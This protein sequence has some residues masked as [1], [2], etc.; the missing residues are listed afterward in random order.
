MFKPSHVVPAA[1]LIVLAGCTSAGIATTTMPTPASTTSPPPSTT[2][3]PSTW[4]QIWAGP[5]Y[6]ALFDLALAG[7]SGILAVGATNHLHLPPYSGDALFVKLTLDG[8]TSWENT[9][10]GAGYEQAFGVEPAGDE[11]FYIL[12]ETD[13]YGAGDRDFFLLEIAGDGTERWHRTY[14]GPG[15]EWPYGMLLLANG[16]LF[17]YGFTE[18]PVTGARNRYALRVDPAGEVVWELVGHGPGEELILDALETSE[19][20]LVLAMA[21]DEDGGLVGLG[22]DGDLE[23]ERRYELAGWQYPSQ[24]APT[25]DG[26][27][28]LAGFSMSDVPPRQADTWLARCNSAGELEWEISV[29]DP[30][31]DDY[32]TS[33]IRL[34]DGTYLIGAIANGLLLSRVDDDGNVLWRQSTLGQ[35]VH[36]VMALAELEDGGY[37]A[38][39]LVQLVN[40]RSY[41]AVLARTDSEGGVGE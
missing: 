26:G 13:S 31:S 10:G 2:A 27:Y 11:G 12:G 15:R 18:S 22:A 4:L 35:T 40:G 20:T 7:E 17:L 14:G 6:G 32:A 23:W 9:W 5:E 30:A 28:F 24:V 29:G 3:A 41:D 37:L 21:V 33:L 38:A 8:E 19:G 1:L 25:E 39:G 34:R 36:G 16:D